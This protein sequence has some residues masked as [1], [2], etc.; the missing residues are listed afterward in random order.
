MITILW[1]CGTHTYRNT[2]QNVS[3]SNRSKHKR[4]EDVLHSG[5]PTGCKCMIILNMKDEFNPWVTLHLMSDVYYEM[6]KINSSWI[7][8]KHIFTRWISKTQFHKINLTSEWK[9]ETM[10]IGPNPNMHFTHFFTFF[11]WWWDLHV[12]L[13]ISSFTFSQRVWVFLV[14]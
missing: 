10:C 12:A 9:I 2:W 13:L 4:T 11:G 5:L 8:L 3:A 7:L 6:D 14:C 1:S